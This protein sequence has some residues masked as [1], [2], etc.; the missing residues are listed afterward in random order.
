MKTKKYFFTKLHAFSFIEPHETNF[1]IT[2]CKKL[3][4]NRISWNTSQ[5]RMGLVSS[6]SRMKILSY[7]VKFIF[8]VFGWIFI[9]CAWFWLF[10]PFFQICEFKHFLNLGSHEDQE[11]STWLI[12]M[13]IQSFGK[14]SSL[15]IFKISSCDSSPSLITNRDKS[16]K[17]DKMI[18][19]HPNPI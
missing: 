2:D 10:N 19:T 11:S 17:V 15:V 18:S 5:N 9:A 7:E 1:F 14:F 13:H 6:W 12:K 4:F 16:L 3:I 8:L